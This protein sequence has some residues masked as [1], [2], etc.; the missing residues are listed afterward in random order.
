M[1]H[2]RQP[3]P[4][5]TKLVGA[6]ASTALLAGCSVIENTE[7]ASENTSSFDPS[8]SVPTSII[9]IGGDLFCYSRYHRADFMPK[10]QGTVVVDGRCADEP[11]EEVGIYN[12]ANYDKAALASARTGAVL[13]ALCIGGGDPVQ[14][15]AGE[16]YF[17]DEMFGKWIQ[18]KLEKTYTPK[19]DIKRIGQ[20]SSTETPFI[21]AVW[22]QG[23]GTIKRQ[24]EN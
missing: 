6:I 11:N 15:L 18:V 8:L 4:L 20:Y 24:C 23:A 3:Y 22:V 19:S 9:S 12:G 7:P 21:P 17:G 2:D 5:R 16:P 10:E 1:E 13:V 14:N